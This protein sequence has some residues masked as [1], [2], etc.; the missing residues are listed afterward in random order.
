MQAFAKDANGEAQNKRLTYTSSI[1]MI[2][3]KVSPILVVAGIRFS[4]GWFD[5]HFETTKG[6]PETITIGEGKELSFFYMNFFS[7]PIIATNDVTTPLPCNLRI[8]SASSMGAPALLGYM[9]VKGGELTLD[10][11]N[12]AKQY[13][14]TGYPGFVPK[15]GF[16]LTQAL[17]W[18][19]WTIFGGP[20]L[21][22]MLTPI[23]GGCVNMFIIITDLISG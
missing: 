9:K 6:I 5:S 2:G 16:S 20:F 12:E 1:D 14:G 7:A 10:L 19:T 4:W 15:L 13:A 22:V 18:T 11:E 17:C 21:A 23:L 8:I 3:L